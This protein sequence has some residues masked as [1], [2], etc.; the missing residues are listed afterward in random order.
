M[1]RCLSCALCSSV[2]SIV[3]SRLIRVSLTV[4]SLLVSMLDLIGVMLMTIVQ[5]VLC[6]VYC[7]KCIVQSVL[8]KVYCAKCIGAVGEILNNVLRYQS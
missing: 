7:A 4:Q 3:L 5:S 6:K 2:D 1:L 8:C